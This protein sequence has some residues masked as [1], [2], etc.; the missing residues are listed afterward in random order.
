MSDRLVVALYDRVIGWL[1]RDS[2]GPSFCYHRDYER[3]NLPLSVRMPVST[4][5]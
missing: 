5:K 1:D 4:R 2:E 3:S